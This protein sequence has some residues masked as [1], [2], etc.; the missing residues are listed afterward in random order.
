MSDRQFACRYKI[1]IDQDWGDGVSGDQRRSAKPELVNVTC[2]PDGEGEHSLTLP[3]VSVISPEL[4]RISWFK[5]QAKPAADNTPALQCWAA[6]CRPAR[7]DSIPEFFMQSSQGQDSCGTRCVL[8]LV[9]WWRVFI[10]CGNCDLC[11]ENRVKSSLFQSFA[12][13]SEPVGI[14]LASLTGIRT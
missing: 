4:K 1:S 3:A 8:A 10:R 13:F 9:L 14:M 11:S 12:T 5:K 7:R 2:S 6:T